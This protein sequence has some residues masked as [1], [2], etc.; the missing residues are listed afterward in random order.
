MVATIVGFLAMLNPFALF[1]YL[2][3][4]MRELD[5]KQFDKVLLRASAISFGICFLFF[6]TGDFIFK[7]IFHVSFDS[8]RVFG[9]IVIFSFAYLFL[10]RG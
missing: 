1:L 10:V 6:L 2:N 5:T 7:H 4:V 3:P 8:F 9:G